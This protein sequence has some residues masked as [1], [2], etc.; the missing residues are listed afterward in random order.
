MLLWLRVNDP[1][2]LTLTCSTEDSRMIKPSKKNRHRIDGGKEVGIMPC[3]GR[4]G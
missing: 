4:T 1:G 3:G 2:I